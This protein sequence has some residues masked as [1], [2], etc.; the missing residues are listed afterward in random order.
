MSST[1]TAPPRQTL[2]A[3]LDALEPDPKADRISIRHL[4]RAIGDNSFA[5]IILVVAVLLVSPISGIPFTPTLG[6]LTILLITAQALTGRRHLWLPGFM[7]RRSISAARLRRGLQSLRRPAGWMDRY[8]R[9]RLGILSSGPFRLLGYLAAA[10]LALSWPMLEILPFI[11]SFSAG[12][13]AMLMFGIVTRDGAYIIAGYAQ[14]GALLA[15]TVAIW[16]GLL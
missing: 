15:G 11:T 5:T 10:T 1:A 2:G 14:G 9:A 8:S 7:M 16:S 4:V 13:V 12:A 3:L 6:A